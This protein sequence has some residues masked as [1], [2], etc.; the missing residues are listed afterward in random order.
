MPII[1]TVIFIFAASAAVFLGRA[2]L[3]AYTDG[4]NLLRRGGR[5]LFGLLSVDGVLLLA[6]LGLM[7]DFSG[8]RG[9]FYELLPDRFI[10][11]VRLLLKFMFGTESVFAV[12]QIAGMYFALFFAVFSCIGCVLG[13]VFCFFCGAAAGKFAGRREETARTGF[14][15]Y[16]L[17]QRNKLFSV[18]SRLQI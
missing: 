10:G 2:K 17:A 11:T 3:S 5:S 7:A 13:F 4:K 15:V 6:T 14:S 16:R 12:L 18:Y 1:K 9:L 8:V